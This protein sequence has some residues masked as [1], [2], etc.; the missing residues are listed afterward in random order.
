MR[1]HGHDTIWDLG[2]AAMIHIHSW[3]HQRTP[4]WQW[5]WQNLNSTSSNFERV[6]HDGFVH[7]LG[8]TL[9]KLLC[10]CSFESSQTPS[11]VA[12]P[13]LGLSWALALDSGK[14]LHA[15]TW[16]KAQR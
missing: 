8:I 10:S 5:Q 2:S 9:P 15:G 3:C 16:R 12:L 14:N 13:L 1:L 6:R 11:P 4:S 7:M